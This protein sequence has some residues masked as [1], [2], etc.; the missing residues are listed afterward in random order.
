MQLRHS[1]DQSDIEAPMCYNCHA[2]MLI[3]IETKGDYALQRAMGLRNRERCGACSLI[4][5]ATA[6]RWCKSV[7][8]SDKQTGNDCT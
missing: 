7:R 5:A 6:T 3:Y 8:D 1:Y 2:Q 4:D